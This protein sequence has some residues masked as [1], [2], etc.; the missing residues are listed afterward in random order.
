MLS[1]LL[2]KT[3]LSFLHVAEHPECGPRCH[4]GRQQERNPVLEERHTGTFVHQSL[5]PGVAAQPRGISASC[6]CVDGLRSNLISE[7]LE[8]VPSL[9][10]HISV[11]KN[12]PS[13]SLCTYMHI[14]LYIYIYV[15]IYIYTPDVTF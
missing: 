7:P 9:D 1:A 5:L 6:S 14:H 3:F 15:F 11:I 8:F 12:V 10:T 13:V 2:N 4:A